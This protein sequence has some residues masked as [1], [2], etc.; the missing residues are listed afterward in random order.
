MRLATC[1][2]VSCIGAFARCM[3]PDV[4]SFISVSSVELGTLCSAPTGL[5]VG[6]LQPGK[7]SRRHL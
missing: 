2:H 7:T 4:V 3:T 6:F 1:D 5:P